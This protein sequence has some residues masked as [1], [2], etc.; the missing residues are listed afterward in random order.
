MRPFNSAS[1]LGGAIVLGSV[2]V[3][4]AV[5]AVLVNNRETAKTADVDP[6]IALA[7]QTP[8][9]RPNGLEEGAA[10][11]AR[12]LVRGAVDGVKQSVKESLSKKSVAARES[13]HQ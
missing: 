12:G 5:A 6:P 7:Q 3:A 9:P 11:V 4:I 1:E 2:V 8:P 13:G 10:D